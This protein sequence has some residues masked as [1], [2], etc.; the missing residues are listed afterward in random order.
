MIYK[1]NSLKT[2]EGAPRAG[3]G[4]AITQ[5][6]GVVQDLHCEMKAFNRMT[7]KAG[8]Y[9]GLHKHEN[10]SEIYLI[11]EGKGEYVDNDGKTYV[12]EPGDMGTCKDGGTHSLK[13]MDGKDLV[14]IA[15]I[16]Q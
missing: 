4:T 7:L 1:L 16:V 6:Y 3:E 13:A 12:L 2:T 11:L 15:I 5:L 9:I 14:F 8:S 10:N